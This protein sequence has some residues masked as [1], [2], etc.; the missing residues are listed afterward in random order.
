MQDIDEMFENLDEPDPI[1]MPDPE[2]IEFMEE[3]ED[4]FG[5]EDYDDAYSDDYCAGCSHTCRH[6]FHRGSVGRQHYCDHYED[7]IYDLSDTCGNWS[8]G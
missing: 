2:V 6:C 8:P 4:L 3:A 7:E 5:D 1:E